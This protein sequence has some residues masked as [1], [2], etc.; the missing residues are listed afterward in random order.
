MLLGFGLL[1]FLVFA[2]LLLLLPVLWGREI[3][4]QYR[5][6]RAVICPETRNQVAVTFNSTHAAISGL[7][8]KTALRI[9][10]CTRWPEHSNCG[11]ECLPDAVRQE[12]YTRGE[13]V[14]RIKRIYH[15]PVLIAT[16]AS[17]YMGAVWHSHYL[18]RAR[19]MAALGLNQ[20]E[21]KQ[22]VWW[23]SPH[24]LSVG[25]CLLFAY[26]VAFLV[27]SYRRQGVALGIVVSTLFWAALALPGV[28]AAS[29]TRISVE[30]LKIELGYTMLASLLVG[31]IIGGLNGKMVLLSE[32]EKTGS[33]VAARGSALNL[34]DRRAS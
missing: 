26:G 11:Q 9:A 34:V 4:N 5:G 20:Q 28:I 8:G 21:L 29:Q 2:S 31:A 14:V 25:M 13:A 16:F 15:L 17:W 30:L 22:I 32:E 7:T 19:W 27:A 6:S 1:L 23:N 10:E 3:C 12:P 18:F 24:L 33:P